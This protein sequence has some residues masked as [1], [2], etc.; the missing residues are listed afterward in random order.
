V[1]LE[2]V[3]IRARRNGR[4]GRNGKTFDAISQNNVVLF[5]EEENK[6]DCKRS[7]SLPELSGKWLG[8]NESGK[9]G[10]VFGFGFGGRKLCDSSPGGGEGGI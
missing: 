7:K 3:S 1:S 5:K 6:K 4:S 2:E 10:E 9:R 8:N